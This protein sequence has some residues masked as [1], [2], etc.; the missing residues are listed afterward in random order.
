MCPARTMPRCRFA[1]RRARGPD[2]SGAVLLPSPRRANPLARIG[3]HYR[4]AAGTAVPLRRS[5]LQWN[6]KKGWKN[7]GRTQY[8]TKTDIVVAIVGLI[9][10]AI[11]TARVVPIVVERAA[12]HDLSRPPDRMLPT[13][14]GMIAQKKLGTAGEVSPAP[15][16]ETEPPESRSAELPEDRVMKQG[17]NAI[18]HENRN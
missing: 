13:G 5:T 12:A 10:V 4:N 14:E 2:L 15:P 1:L 3:P 9:P 7:V 11:G 6:Q 17:Q 16:P 8:H 18:P